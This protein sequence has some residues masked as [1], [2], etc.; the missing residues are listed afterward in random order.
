M[1]NLSIKSKLWLLVA[2]LMVVLAI[3]AGW[4]FERLYTA[5]LAIESIY[6]NQVV[7]LKQMADITAG[8]VDQVQDPLEKMQLGQMDAVQ[9]AQSVEAGIQAINSNWK[10]F[11]GTTLF[12]EEQ[13]MVAR[14]DPLVQKAAPVIEQLLAHL[15]AGAMDQAVQLQQTT[16]TPILTPLLAE[17][18]NISAVQLTNARNTA[19]QSKSAMQTMFWVVG[20][21]VVV[22]F[23][24]C[25]LAAYALIK[26]IT[27]NINHAVQV[28]ERVASGDLTA[29]IAI[30]SQDET[31]RL[32]T[33][34]RAMNTS[35][36]QIVRQIRDS[37]ESIVMGSS[38]ISIGNNDLSQRTEEQASNLQ[39]TAASMEQLASTVRQNSDNANQA[40]QLSSRASRTASEGGE[41][42]QRVN[43]S[44]G[45]ISDSSKKIADIIG[46]ID[47]IAFQTN[48]L[49][50]N[51]AVEAA[52]AGEQGRGFAVVAGEVRSL[53]GR[54]AEAAKEIKQ[55]ISQSVNQVNIG[56][57]LVDETTQTMNTIVQQVRE[58]ATL[59]TE[60]SSASSE[61]SQGVQQVSDAVA[62]LDQV[63][64][65]NAALVEES[66]AAAASLNQQAQDLAR[67]VAAFKL[68]E[69]DVAPRAAVRSNLMQ[70]S[71][72]T[73][74]TRPSA[75]SASTTPTPAPAAAAKPTA[76]LK[77]PV[78]PAATPNNTVHQEDDW[79]T[80]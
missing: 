3:A 39:Q 76:A 40:T 55:L 52:R 50:L 42:M 28:A 6:D 36:V 61:Q 31:G 26:G 53:A 59:I 33:A 16:L 77:A 46:V 5:N 54:S 15:R 68:K 8:Y 1:K 13:A 23:G 48:I 79:E 43:E 41:A 65:Q 51:A 47:S 70:A 4:L 11:M 2:G 17:I 63:T 72:F 69:S 25:I 58:A 71:N 56:A 27:G 12:A 67:V 64:Q 60:I 32:L 21:G 38:E 30:T 22:V 14:A 73:P 66:A 57:K 45:Q 24:L 35:L 49:A 19:E 34:L 62:Q 37:S 9:A 80:F 75:P 10:A 29:D 7:P 18:N 20:V 44:M 74:V 78:K